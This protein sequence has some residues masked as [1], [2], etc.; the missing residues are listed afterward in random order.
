M[1]EDYTPQGFP[2]PDLAADLGE[3]LKSAHTLD[4]MRQGKGQRIVGRIPLTFEGNPV[5]HG[6]RTDANLDELVMHAYGFCERDAI[7]NRKGSCLYR[8]R[9]SYCAGRGGFAAEGRS[10]EL[11]IGE[12]PEEEEATD[13]RAR[14]ELLTEMRSERRVLF[15]QHIKLLATT[16]AM[17]ASVSTM[18]TGLATAFGAV[19]E[20][21]RAVAEAGIDRAVLQA[22]TD[23]SRER[24]RMLE[25]MLLPTLGLV[26]AKLGV[27][28]AIAVAALPAASGASS[29]LVTLARKLGGSLSAEQLEV[30]A[31]ELGSS[32][33]L[34]DLS[35]VESDGDTLATLSWLFERDMTPLMRV[36]ATL[37]A[38]QVPIVERL[39]ALALAAADAIDATRAAG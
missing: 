37:T 17:A 34:R 9:A 10:V 13:R 29:E 20:K 26:R 33:R 18:A 12:P 28:E 5:A 14:F 31:R 23:S 19:W 32:S 16:T 3:I 25:K 38:S 4:C 30:A 35:T 8:L 27:P 6:Q 24:W 21:E 11:Q 2:P 39:Q 22:E 15:E 7:A 1:P 36:Y